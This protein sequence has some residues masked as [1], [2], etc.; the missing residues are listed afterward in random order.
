MENL[1]TI[2]NKLLKRAIE[3][4]EIEGIKIGNIN[5]EVVI[6]SRAKTRWGL[7]SKK[8]SMYEI[9]I[10][11]S[12]LEH[13]EEGALEILVHEVLH[14][15][16]GCFNHGWKWKNFACRINRKQGFN[17][18]RCAT[19]PEVEKIM[20]E[21]TGGKDYKY[22]FKCEDCNGQINYMRK[23]RAVK[24]YETNPELIRCG[25][26]KGRLTRIK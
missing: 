4:V 13:H 14:T 18:S 19:F 21:T 9:Q 26:C 5:N 7:C 8:Q 1:Q 12:L 23:G 20:N 22:I 11:K 16:D 24:V 6:N 25:R 15:V 3:I 2:G 10:N 17:I